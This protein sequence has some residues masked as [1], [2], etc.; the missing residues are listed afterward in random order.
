[1]TGKTFSSNVAGRAAA[2]TM[3]N[4]GA[5]NIT[6]T[7]SPVT[8]P[9]GYHNGSGQV[10]GDSDLIAANIIMSARRVA[11]GRVTVPESEV[12]YTIAVG[13]RPAVAV[14]WDRYWNRP[15]IG[16][17]RA[18]TSSY[19]ESHP[20]SGYVYVKNPTSTGFDVNIPGTASN[21]EVDY[22]AAEVE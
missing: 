5:Y 16:F 1:L 20:N 8:I 12:D 9:N 11:F 13:F 19:W 22:Y 14:V 21:V 17:Y 6:P 7:T 10:A 3:P 15:G 4:R 18:R 2:G